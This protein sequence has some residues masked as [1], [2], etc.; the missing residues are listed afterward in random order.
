M[1]TPSKSLCRS[2][3]HSLRQVLR[4]A[5]KQEQRNL[6][7]ES[8][9]PRQLLAANPIIT[10]FMADNDDNVGLGET[11]TIFGKPD[12]FG[13]GSSPDWVEIFNAGDE[14]LDLAGYRLTDDADL[15]AQWTFPS[16][17]LEPGK[18]LL[19]YASGMTGANGSDSVDEQG[20]MHANFGLNNE[21]D[22]LA[23][24][25]P[26]GQTV[27]SQF[28]KDGRDFPGQ[29]SDVS[30]GYVQTTRLIQPEDE[31]TF[32][33]PLNGD[34][35]TSWTEPNFDP[36]AKGFTPGTASL[37]FETRPADRTNFAGQYATE[38]PPGSHAVFVRMEFDVEDASAVS[39]LLMRL[40]Y[41]NGFVA[42]MNGVEVLRENV[43]DNAGWFSTATSGS[44]RDSQALEF[45]P[46]T[47]DQHVG[48]LR[49]GKN[50]LAIHLLDNLTDNSD[51]LLGVELFSDKPVTSSNVGYLATPTPGAANIVFDAYTGPL[52]SHVTQNPGAITDDQ[53][54]LVTAIVRQHNAP[55]ETVS[56]QYRVMFDAEVALRMVDDGTGGDATAGDGIYSAKIP[57]SAAAPG[58]MVRWRVTATDTDGNSMQW[59]LFADPFDSERYYG[60]IVDDPSIQSTMTVLHWFIENPRAAEAATGGRGAFFYL[61]EFYDNVPADIHGQSSSGFPKKS[62][63]IDFNAGHR[64]KWKEGEARVRDINL[65]GNWADKG[66]FRNAIPYDMH[67]DAGA[68]YLFAFPVRLEQNGEFFSIADIVEDADDRTLER[69]G[70]NPDGS[71]YK[72]YSTF[73]RSVTAEE[74]KS[75]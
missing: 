48:T 56:L 44:R 34:L 13:D 75:R 36:L 70:L 12:P 29:E 3:K 64:F 67:R 51:M 65:L 38:I 35:G 23:L 40:Q 11:E 26:D 66:K 50:V 30:Y 27:L 74:K 9:E 31:A 41:D 62:Y 32:W 17:V 68:P 49:T 53:D 63:D 4:G 24:L 2:R 37:G 33:V 6:G 72:M 58:Q 16:V 71:L 21:G 28:A 47:L 69:L 61:G 14:A 18:H 25:S 39:S 5:L 60:T 57:A 10:E 52:V 46:F 54:L 55:V 73:T 22:Y 43:P 42:Y 8:L 59:P 20:R 15:A 45:T 7:L 19:V 1:R